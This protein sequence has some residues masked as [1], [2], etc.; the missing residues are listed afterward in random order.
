MKK[1]RQHNGLK[2]KTKEQRT[3]YK[4]LHR[5]LK[6][7]LK[8]GGEHKCS[9][10][11]GN[12]CSNSGTRRVNQL[13]NR[14]YIMNSG[15]TFYWFSC[16]F[17]SNFPAIS[18]QEQVN[19]QWNDEDVRFVLDQYS[20]MDFYCSSSLTKQST[21]WHAAPLGNIILFW[22]RQSLLFLLNAAYLAEKQHIQ[23][24]YASV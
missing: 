5:K 8:T 11:V 16:F 12:F 2:K 22:D 14:W 21:D 17:L 18:W 1:E 19:L 20:S 7:P 13:Q 15:E 3:I 6:T 24:S 9:G 23:I 10:R 4:T